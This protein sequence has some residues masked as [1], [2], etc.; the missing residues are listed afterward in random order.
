[1]FNNWIAQGL[2]KVSAILAWAL[3]G[4]QFPDVLK[5]E[6]I[7]LTSCLALRQKDFISG[8]VRNIT[9]VSAMEDTLQ[10]N[11]GSCRSLSFTSS[12]LKQL[13]SS[14]NLKTEEFGNGE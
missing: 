13:T 7:R 11:S 2:G 1:M 12:L 4:K 3:G 6:I 5:A 9:M 8:M 14:S 10:L